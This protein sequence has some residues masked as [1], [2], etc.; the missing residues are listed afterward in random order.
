MKWKRRKEKKL[1]GCA[2]GQQSHRGGAPGETDVI[3]VII[4]KSSFSSPQASNFDKNT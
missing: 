3:I 2:E 4:I 1:V